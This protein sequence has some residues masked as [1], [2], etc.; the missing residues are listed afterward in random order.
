[1]VARFT[2]GLPPAELKIFGLGTLA[3]PFFGATGFGLGMGVSDFGRVADIYDATRS[4]PDG[5]MRLVVDAVVS[6][7]PGDGPVVDVGV[8][9]GRF[10][11]PL[12]E[13]GLDVVGLDISR[14]MMSKAK[15]KGVRELVFAD[16]QR[17]PFRDAV[18]EA[19][20][21]VHILH[22]VEDWAAVVR[23][24]ARVSRS[25]V[26]TVLGSGGGSGRRLMREEY[27]KARAR[28]GFPLNRFGDGEDGLLESVP[29]D[30]LVRVVEAERVTIADDEIHRLEDRSQSV[31]WDIPDDVHA[32]IVSS[33]KEKY[34]GTTFRS[35]TR[36]DVAVWSAPRLRGLGL[37]Q[38]QKG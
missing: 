16:V 8:G 4:L 21:L 36:I 28:E 11:K 6:S 37:G 10:A 30:R 24:A 15:E 18:F 3:I 29:P 19:S 23:E 1:M 34:G 5:E 17:V 33:L 25:S 26:I 9:T 22:L 13:R 27:R 12:Q 32:R 14:G 38:H 2:F 7:V 31:T 35:T 20:L